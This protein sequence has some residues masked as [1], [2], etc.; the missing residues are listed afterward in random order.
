MA[1]A[2]ISF[3]KKD[4]ALSLANTSALFSRLIDGTLG[5]VEKELR[6]GG[7]TEM[8]IHAFHHIQMNIDDDAN[9][10]SV[11]VTVDFTIDGGEEQTTT[12]HFCV[13]HNGKVELDFS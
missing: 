5:D 9:V 10:Y 11:A 8:V 1:M 4:Q 7:N 2:Q 13:D 3:I 6:A 12:I